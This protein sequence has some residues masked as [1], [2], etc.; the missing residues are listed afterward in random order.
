MRSVMVVKR[1]GR[2]E[3]F[4]REKLF[5]SLSKACAKRPLPVGSIEKVLDEVEAR[6]TESGRA[7]VSSRAVGEMVMEKI[8]DLDRVAYIR[9]ASVYRTSGTS[10][11]LK[12]RSMPCCSPASRKTLCIRTRSR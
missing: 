12:R 2:R 1:D 10:R 4:E 9:F 8:K 11:A 5:T 6:V 7:E 3:E